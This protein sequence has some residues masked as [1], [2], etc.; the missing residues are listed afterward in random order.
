MKERGGII[1]WTQAR[2]GELIRNSPFT[3]FNAGLGLIG[4]PPIVCYVLFTAVMHD[5]HASRVANGILAVAVSITISCVM[6][7][8]GLWGLVCLRVILSLVPRSRLVNPGP[9]PPTP[10]GPAE[11]N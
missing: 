2:F 8:L 6:A 1:A 9:S 7:G 10:D 4:L 3:L 5:I 11:S